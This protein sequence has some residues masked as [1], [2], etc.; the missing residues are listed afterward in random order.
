MRN[1][2]ETRLEN[3][4]MVNAEVKGPGLFDNTLNKKYVVVVDGEFL[5]K[6]DA[7][8]H[9]H[10]RTFETQEGAEK[11]ARKEEVL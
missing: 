1:E 3:E 11:A 2:N 5:L 4:T 10:V 8:G 6:E 9:K 7:Y